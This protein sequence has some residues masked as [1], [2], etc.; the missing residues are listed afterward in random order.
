MQKTIFFFNVK[1]DTNEEMRNLK[2]NERQSFLTA[3]CT[4]FGYVF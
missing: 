4:D 2:I 1:R 3:C